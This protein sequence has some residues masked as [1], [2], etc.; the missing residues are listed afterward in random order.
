MQ[1]KWRE[2]NSIVSKYYIEYPYF[3]YKNDQY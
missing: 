1:K 2:K 3:L